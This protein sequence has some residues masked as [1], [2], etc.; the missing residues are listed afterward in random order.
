MKALL[1]EDKEHIRKGLLRLL[2]LV[3]AEINV[4]GECSSVIEAV[5]VANARKPDLIF[6][7]INLI[8]GTGFDFLDQTEN[9]DFRVIFITAY[10]EYAL[11][12]LKLGAVD[13]L[14]KPVDIDDLKTALQKVAKL[15][16][17]EQ[18]QN[19]KTAKAAWKN[20]TSKLILSLHDSFQV[21]DLNELLYCE[22]DKGY[23]TFYCNNG[24][25]HLVSKTLKEFEEPLVAANFVRPHQSFMVNLD[26]IDK[27]DKSGVIYLKNGTKIPVSSRK[28][29]SFVSA[30]LNKR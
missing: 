27:Y 26:F 22:S 23:T 16:V 5:A 6:L 9:L 25:K 29:E 15:P 28:K 11:R 17:A 3:D 13:Y 10:E 18:R 30:F 4:V 24:K 2:E 21:I 12:A 1:V 14:L 7:D 8:D 19:I 20:D